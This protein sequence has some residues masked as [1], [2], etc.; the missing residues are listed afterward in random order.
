MAMNYKTLEQQDIV[1]QAVHNTLGFY[2]QKV[3]HR[4]EC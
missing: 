1:S 2:T 4:M 3:S